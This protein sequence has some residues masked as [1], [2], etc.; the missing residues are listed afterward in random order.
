MDREETVFVE[1]TDDW[2]GVRQW[3]RAQLRLDAP[4]GRLFLHVKGSFWRKEK[5]VEIEAGQIR[6]A[7]IE[8]VSNPHMFWYELAS[9]AVVSLF[10]QSVIQATGWERSS[11]WRF[12]L[13]LV[14][15]AVTGAVALG[16]GALI[17]V[18]VVQLT[19]PEEAEKDGKRSLQGVVI[20][21]MHKRRPD[22]SEQEIKAM[23]DSP[24]LLSLIGR[25]LQQA[26]RGSLMDS[27]VYR[28][29]GTGFLSVFRARRFTES[30][31]RWLNDRRA[32]SL[33]L[34]AKPVVWGR[35]QTVVLM[36]E[37]I[38]VLIFLGIA[39]Y[40]ISMIFQG[41]NL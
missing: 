32:V 33:E 26:G 3:R 22:L 13:D 29:Y 10:L 17:R 7:K 19:L 12:L 39:G 27:S 41:G 24:E 40:V 23:M 35:I 30:L 2:S 11:I 14:P 1:F 31:E 4:S 28:F 5:R 37:I 34:P 15:L 6:Q 8:Y 21:E 38:A 16:L 9:L 20:S 25:V 18:P 36:G